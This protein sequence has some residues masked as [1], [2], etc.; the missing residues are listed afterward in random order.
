MPVVNQKVNNSIVTN[1]S[2]N[3]D[4]IELVNSTASQINV[5]QQ[6]GSENVVSL[7]FKLIQ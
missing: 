3:S 5:L 6:K 4:V 1:E 2:I 7:S